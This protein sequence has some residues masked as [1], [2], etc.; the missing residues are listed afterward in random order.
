MPDR[1]QLSRAAGWRM[2][3][4]TAKV[5]RTTIWGNPWKVGSPGW[6]SLTAM[7]S[8]Y[9]LRLPIDRRSAVNAF[10]LWLTEDAEWWMLPPVDQFSTRGLDALWSALNGKRDLILS[11]LPSLRGMHLG[12]WC[13]P[14]SP[15]HADVL[16]DMANR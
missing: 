6:L 12:C 16:M 11:R 13:K 2:P 4:N 14:G 10:R 5:D 9:K 1:I 7:P 15:C 8:D 3:P